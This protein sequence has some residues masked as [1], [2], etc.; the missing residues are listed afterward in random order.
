MLCYAILSSE[1]NELGISHVEQ[2]KKPKYLGFHPIVPPIRPHTAIFTQYEP[3][4]KRPYPIPQD[5]ID[6]ASD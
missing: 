5:A 4:S 1:S 6:L 2:G 3:H